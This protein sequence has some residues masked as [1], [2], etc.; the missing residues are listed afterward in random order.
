MRQFV[1]VS[2][3]ALLVT[4]AKSFAVCSDPHNILGQYDAMLGTVSF[5]DAFHLGDTAIYSF[6]GYPNTVSTK[7]SS[8]T[9]NDVVLDADGET[10]TITRAEYNAFNGSYL[11]VICNGEKGFATVPATDVELV[12]ATPT[13]VSLPHYPNINAI[14]VHAVLSYT[15]SNGTV[16]TFEE[17]FTMG[18]GLPAI[19]QYL[20]TEYDQNGHHYK[21]VATDVVRIM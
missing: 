10:E 16:S 17:D 8:V 9:A 18:V 4:G 20:G 1:F 7:V 6:V 19:G 14:V 13:T 21:I 2:L 15:N 11:R 12:S 3:I 5:E